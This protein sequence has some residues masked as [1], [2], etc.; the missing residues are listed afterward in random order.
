MVSSR[1]AAKPLKNQELSLDV[2]AKNLARDVAVRTMRV[3]CIGRFCLWGSF[4]GGSSTKLLLWQAGCLVPLGVALFEP[5][6][7]P[8]GCS[9]LVARVLATGWEGLDPYLRWVFF[10]NGN[11]EFTLLKHQDGLPPAITAVWQ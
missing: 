7:T 8:R 5:W 1:S 6:A 3:T 4:A 10:V 11:A 9:T 2:I